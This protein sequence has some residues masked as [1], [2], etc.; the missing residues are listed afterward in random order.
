M[1]FRDPKRLFAAV[2]RLVGPPDRPAR[3]GH[4]F[5]IEV[6]SSDGVR[7]GVPVE[8][9]THRTHVTNGMLNNIADCW[10][11]PHDEIEDVL[12]NWTP[13]QLEEHLSQFTQEELRPPFLR[14]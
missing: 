6:T 13:E 8:V 11:I 7:C 3:H 1:G 12:E 2:T 10:R 5:R 9:S 4:F 14:R